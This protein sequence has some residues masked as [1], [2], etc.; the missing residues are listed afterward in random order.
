MHFFYYRYPHRRLS[1]YE[2]DN[3]MHIACMYVCTYVCAARRVRTLTLNCDEP[4]LKSFPSHFHQVYVPVAIVH[5]G[6]LRCCR[7]TK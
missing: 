4:N 3:K 7:E 1:A 6:F 5:V 2:C